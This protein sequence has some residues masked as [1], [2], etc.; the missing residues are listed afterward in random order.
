MYEA[1]TEDGDRAA[2]KQLLMENEEK[3]KIIAQNLE[4]LRKLK[5][6]NLVKIYQIR[7]ETNTVWIY[8]EFCKF[9]DLN[10]FFHRSPLPIVQQ[11][12]LM[13]DIAKGVRFLH[14]NNIIH[15]DIKPGNILI[16]GKFRASGSS[17]ASYT[18]KLTDFDLSKHLEEGYVTSLM[19]TDV[20]TREYKAPEFW[21]PGLDR[22]MKYHRNIDVYSTGLTFLAMIQGEN[23]LRP[24]I[25]TPVEPSELHAPVGQSISERIRFNLTPTDVIPESSLAPQASLR[26]DLGMEIQLKRLIQKMTRAQPKYRLSAAEVVDELSSFTL[27]SFL[28]FCSFSFSLLAWCTR[29][30]R[31]SCEPI[32]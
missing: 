19:T 29:I 8:M 5:H 20:G 22:K 11:L 1:K 16:K 15:R 9:G 24:C 32:A 13:K 28:C 31:I 27:V 18:A 25:E 6:A 2:A 7:R 21:F 12:H 26:Q 17:G 14:R 30:L 4:K 10:R 3:L 23:P